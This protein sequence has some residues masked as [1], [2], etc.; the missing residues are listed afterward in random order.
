MVGL[1]IDLSPSTRIIGRDLSAL[2]AGF[3][4]YRLPLRQSVDHVMIPAIAHQFEV[5]GD[6]AWEPLAEATQ[7]RR[8][9][10]GTLGGEPQ[11]ILVETGRLF[12]AATARARWSFTPDEAWFSNLPSQAEYGIVHQTG[13]HNARTGG[14]IP[15]RPFVRGSTEDVDAVEDI[16]QRWARGLIIVNWL[17]RARR[18]L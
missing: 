13:G 3:R 2:A 9:R 17:K 14:F 10:E 12:S 8:D 15:A 11:D 6:P 16:F 18:F 7:E 1:D 4:T 5:G